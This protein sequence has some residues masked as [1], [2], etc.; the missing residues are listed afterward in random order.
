MARGRGVGSQM[1]RAC[2]A[3]LAE[4]QIAKLNLMVRGDNARARAFYAAQ[5]Y[6]VDDVVVLSRRLR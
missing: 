6:D 3:W 4:R 1:M 2:E 5:G